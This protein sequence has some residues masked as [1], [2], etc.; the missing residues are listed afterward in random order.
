M[1]AEESQTAEALASTEMES[2]DWLQTPLGAIA[3]WSDELKTAVQRHLTKLAQ[4]KPA[5]KT[6]RE[7][8]LPQNRA[9]AV[10][11]QVAQANAFRVRL[12]DALRPLTD[13]T[14][15]QAIAAR[16]LGETLGVTRVIYIEVVSDGEEVVVHRNYTNGVAQLSGRYRLEDYRRNLAADHRAGH[17]Q[18]VTDI[19]NHPDYTDAEK[20]RY[21]EIDIA[22]HIDV[23]LIKNNQFVALLAAQQS[24]PRKWTATEVKLVEET[25]EQTWVAVERARAEGALRESEERYRMLFESIDEGF[26]VVEVLFDAAGTPVDHRILQANP[27][28]ERQTGIIN[29]EGKVASELAPGLERYWNDLYAQVIHTGESIRVENRSD[30]LDR[31]F[32]VSVSRVGNAAMHQ[33]AIVF[34]DISDRKRT[35]AALRQSEQRFRLMADAVPQIVWITDAE[36]RVEFFNKQWSAYTG[37]AYE[38]ATAAAV[39]ARFVHPEDSDRTIAAFNEARCTGGVFSVEHRIRSAAGTY[40]WFLVRAELYRDPQTGEIVRWFGASIDIDDRKQAETALR[41]SEAFNRSIIESSADCIKVL[42]LNGY[43]LTLN[44]P[45][46]CLLELEDCSLLVGTPWIEFWQESDRT[47]ASQAVNTAIAGETGRFSGYCPT[48]KGT[49]KW[50]DVMLTPILDIT[51]K[52]KELLVVSRDITDRKQAEAALQESEARFRNLADNIVQFAWIADATGWIFWYNQRWF[53]YTGTTLEQMQGWGWQQVHHPDHVKRVVEHI[54]DCF[55]TGKE[56]EDTFPLRDKDGKYRWFLSR[57]VPIRDEQGRILSWFGTNTD[58]SDRVQFERDRERIL[59]QEQAAREAAERANKIKDEF[60][61]VLSHELRSPLNPIL[62][63]T[64]LLQNRKL[65]AARQ[66]EA[67]AVIERNAKLQTQLIEDL[68]DISRI[69]QGKLALN[70]AP[71]SLT[72]VISAAVETVR[73]AAEAKKIEIVLDLDPFVASVSGDAARLQQ[74]VWNLL[75]NAVKFT[76]N[77]GQ[78]TVELRQ[79]N[80]LA[81]IRVLDTGK[82]INPQFL[83]HVFEYFRQEDGSTT[84]QFGGLGLGLAIVR[85]IVELHGGRVGA[86]SGGENQGATFIVQLP[87]AQQMVA[88]ASEPIQTQTEV[89]APLAGIQILLVDDEPDTREFQAFVLSQSGAT[90][91]AVASGFE[92]LQVLEEFIPDVLVSD[93]GMAGMDGYTLLQQ[94][95]SR[96]ASLSNSLNRGGTMRAIALTAYAADIDRQRVLRAGF[97]THLTKPVEPEELVRTITSL[98]ER[99]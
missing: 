88:N 43:L 38:P 19:P 48:M 12:A 58:I 21:R 37:V 97:Q 61:A 90:V 39:A 18:I 57:A 31:W 79:I 32:N 53:D 99:N 46:K 76:P 17:T 41:E 9:A 68:L 71:V 98:L 44:K 36:G 74:V 91:T 8:D 33:V 25:A 34:S 29:P 4:A 52:P 5:A 11:L 26:C 35:E 20:A 30:A 83:P 96:E 16:I 82:G 63:W 27:A 95:R 77:N 7:I 10:L 72:F 64:R 70:V 59:Q 86:E 45:G 50:W 84:R 85:Q 78:V 65:D 2:H 28:F 47:S 69:M 42:D 92:A 13:V 87:T 23:P 81:Q 62:G 6:A 24:T 15:I 54:R 40:R 51:G 56:W 3:T 60:L 14:E 89:E 55:E 73:L 93:I 22:A 1:R 80:Q 66:K 94:I 75:S 49:P 67:L